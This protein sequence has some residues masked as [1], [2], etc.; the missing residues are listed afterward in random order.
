[1]SVTSVLPA[2][3]IALIQNI[4]SMGNSYLHIPDFPNEVYFDMRLTATINGSYSEA[5]IFSIFVSPE[6]FETKAGI[7]QLAKNEAE[8]VYREANRVVQFR[9][10]HDAKME[11][12][13]IARIDEIAA[14]F[15]LTIT[16]ITA[17][18][19]AYLLS[20]F[21]GMNGIAETIFVT[22]TPFDRNEWKF[23]YLMMEAPHSVLRDTSVHYGTQEEAMETFV[24]GYQR[25]TA[26]YMISSEESNAALTG[27]TLP[28]Q[29]VFN[30][31]D[32]LER[33]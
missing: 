19:P 32:Y 30:I 20:D 25:N 27:I 5:T 9:R 18:V 6:N 28:W 16:P 8:S 24:S 13:R 31:E 10:E 7:W 15:P 17:V 4:G 1:M 22:V 29:E 26:H 11:A 23:T 3:R 12:L 21:V 2:D 33:D 14:L